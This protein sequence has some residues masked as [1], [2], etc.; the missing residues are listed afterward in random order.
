MTDLSAADMITALAMH[1]EGLMGMDELHW[2][3]EQ[4]LPIPSAVI[5]EIGSWKGRSTRGL[6]LAAMGT[7]GVVFA[8]DAWQGS[9]S[10]PTDSLVNAVPGH[11]AFDAFRAANADLLSMGY[12]VPLHL[13]SVEAAVAMRR[14]GMEQH[15][16]LLFV[17][18]DHRY[19]CVKA[20][21]EAW[22]PLVKPG[23]VVCGHDWTRE[24]DVARAVR[25]FL[26]DAQGAVG[27]MWLA[28]KSGE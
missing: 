24:E 12:I 23:G 5:V 11:E 28:R 13:R 15:I 2:L 19:E 14:L 7:G 3:V 21:L 16:D 27:G 25:E 20:D 4:A 22:L 18:G 10:E 17:D 9:A 1:V 26:P 8:V 6:G